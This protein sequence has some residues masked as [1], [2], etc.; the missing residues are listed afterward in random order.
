[1]TPL[2]IT[3]RRSHDG[4]WAF[5]WQTEHTSKQWRGGYRDRDHAWRGCKRDMQEK[6]EWSCDTCGHVLDDDGTCCHC[7]KMREPIYI[8]SSITDKIDFTP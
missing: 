1:M 8:P 4:S 2:T 5:G 7:V 6:G 3:L